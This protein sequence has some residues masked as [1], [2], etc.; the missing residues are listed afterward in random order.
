MQ[1]NNKYI[2]FDK[3]VFTSLI[4]P[5]LTAIEKGDHMIKSV[6]GLV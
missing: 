4:L 3:K 5:S 2:C 6:T 1:N